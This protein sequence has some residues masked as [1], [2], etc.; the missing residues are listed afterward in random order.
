MPQES[1][2]NDSDAATAIDEKPSLD[3]NTPYHGVL[4]VLES[5]DLSSLPP[6]IR[7]V[8]LAQIQA[9]FNNFPTAISMAVEAFHKE[10]DGEWEVDI[11][12]PMHDSFLFKP[13]FRGDFSYD[14]LRSQ[15]ETALAFHLDYLRG[16][17]ERQ[18]ADPFG[19]KPHAI[20]SLA[21]YARNEWPSVDELVAIAI[22]K[23][24]SR[25][26]ATAFEM[27]LD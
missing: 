23:T 1:P 6:P 25:H 4:N 12:L 5:V 19:K 20:K 13:V 27:I 21:S 2:R 8:V 22:K 26:L 16:Q 10:N 7:N 3:V 14:N 17:S 24:M 15:M 9:F 18:D 11:F